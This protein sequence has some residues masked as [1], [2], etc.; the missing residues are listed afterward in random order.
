MEKDIFHPRPAEV[1]LGKICKME[2][3]PFETGISEVCTQKNGPLKICLHHA[4]SVEIRRLKI[5]G[6]KVRPIQIYTFQV[7]PFKVGLLEIMSGQDLTIL[8]SLLLFLRRPAVP[9]S[10]LSTCAV[11]Q[12]TV[13]TYIAATGGRMSSPC[14]FCLTGTGLI[15]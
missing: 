5:G 13:T 11:F 9:I 15:E 3:G 2:T 1:R 4:G 10:A 6:S 12:R 14:I 8:G 7:R